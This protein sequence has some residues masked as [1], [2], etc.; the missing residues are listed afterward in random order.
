MSF[1]NTK[2]IVYSFNLIVTLLLVVVNNTHASDNRCRDEVVDTSNLSQTNPNAE[3]NGVVAL[4]AFIEMLFDTLNAAPDLD[5]ILEGVNENRQ[6]VQVTIRHLPAT[7]SS[8]ENGYLAVEIQERLNPSE[9]IIL[10]R[11]HADLNRFK[12]S[13]EG[14]GLWYMQ[15]LSDDKNGTEIKRLQFIFSPETNQLSELRILRLRTAPKGLGLDE[16]PDVLAHSI[17]F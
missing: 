6:R 17:F 5:S 14:A 4:D 7:T 9:V 3:I 8:E 10:E 2:L 12:I 11:Q 1:K 15:I 16:L 13:D